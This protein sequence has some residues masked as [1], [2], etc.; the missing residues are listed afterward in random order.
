LPINAPTND[1]SEVPT[2]E[3]QLQNAIQTHLLGAKANKSAF[4]KAYFGIFGTT[5]ANIAEHKKQIIAILEKNNLGVVGSAYNSIGNDFKFFRDG[6]HYPSKQAG[7]E[8]STEKQSK[9]LES[10]PP[11]PTKEEYFVPAVV[12][13]LEG[14]SYKED[15]LA[16]MQKA[17][18]DA[19]KSW[20]K[21]NSQVLADA[22]K[23][24]VGMLNRGTIEKVQ[25]NFSSIQ[26]FKAAQ[27]L[28]SVLDLI[29]NNGLI[30]DATKDAKQEDKQEDKPQND[31]DDK[32][33]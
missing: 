25:K 16:D 6:E 8:K 29:D 19:V 3:E 5:D 17:F 14:K 13:T 30:I 18:E 7:S 22:K 12:A 10:L 21:T 23:G 20:E 31:D 1:T 11:K 15:V 26:D 32:P 28:Q 33:F 24:F 27:I 2:K 9:I 4:S